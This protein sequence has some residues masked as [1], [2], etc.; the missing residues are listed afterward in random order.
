MRHNGRTR[1]V[2]LTA[3]AIWA[4]DFLTKTWAVAALSSSPREIIGTLLQFTLVRNP[5]A[6]FSFA[7]GFTLIFTAIAVSV[8]IFITRYANRFTSQGWALVA[9]LVLGGVSGNLTDRIFREP[10]FLYGHVIDWI[11]LPHWPI[12]NCADSAIVIAA[13]IAFYLTLRG[14]PP[15]AGTSNPKSNTNGETS[16]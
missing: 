8:F 15:I 1:F 11:E 7:T 12:F 3:F 9:G 16:E 5:G 6:A 10:G 4:L 2:F 13:F 14:V